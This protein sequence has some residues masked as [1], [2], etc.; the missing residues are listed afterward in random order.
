MTE[1][2]TAEAKTSCFCMGAGP[3]FFSLFRKMGPGAAARDHFRAARVEFLKGLRS[4]LDDRIEAL[5]RAEKK[6]S[7]VVV[8]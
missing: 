8:E 2:E 1:Q 4:L 3:E 5:S 6:G 7:K